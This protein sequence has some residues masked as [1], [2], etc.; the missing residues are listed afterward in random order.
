[1]T[2]P[3]QPSKVV[4]IEWEDAFIDTDDFT[5]EEAKKTEP[6]YRKTVGFFIAKNQH[7][8]VLSTDVYQKAGDGV[9]ARMFIPWGVI[10]QWYELV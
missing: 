5:I 1:M 6:I 9:S 10:N 7:G 2:P 3:K 4:V 8:I